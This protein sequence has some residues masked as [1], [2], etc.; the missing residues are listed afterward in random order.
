MVDEY[1][2]VLFSSQRREGGLKAGAANGLTNDASLATGGEDYHE[3]VVPV[4]E[5]AGGERIGEVRVAFRRQ[6]VVGKTRELFARSITAGVVVFG[7]AVALLVFAITIWVTKPLKGL[8]E[9]IYDISKEGAESDKRVDVS[10]G[11]ELG[12]LGTA[13]NEMVGKLHASHEDIQQYAEK[14]E[15]KVEERTCELKEA[16]EAAQAANLSKSEFLANMSHEIRTPMTAIMGFADLLLDE[17]SHE[18]SP[19]ERAEAIHTIKLNGDYLLSL[20]ND[21]L[22]LSKIEA[23]QMTIESVSC[24]PRELVDEVISLIKV[25]AAGKDLD[26]HAEYIGEIPEVIESDPI[27]L[28]Q[29]LINLLGNAVKFTERGSVRLVTHLESRRDGQAFLHFDVIDTG[30]G[31]TAKQVEKLFDPFSQA[32]ASTTRRFGGTGL[33]LTISKRLATLLGGDVVIVKTAPNVGSQFRVIVSAGLPDGV[34]MID[35]S[36]EVVTASEVQVSVSAE[37]EGDQVE[38]RILLAEDNE[39]NRMIIVRMLE[40]A[41]ACVTTVENGKQALESALEALDRG[42]PFDV[43]LMDMQMPE[44]D[45]YEATALLRGKRYSGPII[46]LTAHAMASD[47]QKCLDAGCDD[48]TT[49]PINRKTLIGKIRKWQGRRSV[50]PTESV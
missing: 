42:N 24:R 15:S 39:T 26:L 17:T 28:R 34:R 32:D 8:V 13:F 35:E 25:R 44:M 40:K 31:L 7:L 48:Y 11:D 12:Q 50:L 41:G 36:T 22:D 16:T 18:A 49:K 14:L 4:L 43:I 29:I 5:Q 30:L 19:T 3:A 1:G 21:I 33:G 45:G 37:E 9:V 6:L 20:I 38:G 2:T 47:E 27:R 10:S 23:G 46:A